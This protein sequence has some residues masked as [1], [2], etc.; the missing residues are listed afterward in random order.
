MKAK[1]VNQFATR[2]VK[3]VGSFKFFLFIIAWSVIWLSWNLLAPE[4][5]RFDPSPAFVLW[6]FISNV[7]QICL[8]PLVLIGQNVQSDS[9]EKLE[10]KIYLLEKEIKKDLEEIKESLKDK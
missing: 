5:L 7:I 9:I 2:V 1:D 8:M 10:K 6:L 3:N 4:A